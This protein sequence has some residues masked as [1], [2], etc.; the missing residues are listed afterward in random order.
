MIELNKNNIVKLYLLISMPVVSVVL[1]LISGYFFPHYERGKLFN[2]TLSM[3][4]FDS[5]HGDLLIQKKEYIGHI[6]E[7]S[8]IVS[9]NTAKMAIANDLYLFKVWLNN[10]SGRFI[11]ESY[12][13]VE[14]NLGDLS[15]KSMHPR[16][17]N[18]LKS[19]DWQVW[20]TKLKSVFASRIFQIIVVFIGLSSIIWLFVFVKKNKN[21][22]II[23]KLLL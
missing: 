2:P 23:E 12:C 19:S 7:S 6:G 5:E 18:L 14:S 3:H 21:H 22:L 13:S 9:R 15:R 8:W 4:H 1:L 17:V 10:L 11:R 20:F 16:N